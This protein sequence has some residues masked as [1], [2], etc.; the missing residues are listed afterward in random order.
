MPNGLLSR[1]PKQGR[2][3]GPGTRIKRAALFIFFVVFYTLG[4][5]YH[6][7]LWN[8]GQPTAFLT[9]IYHG[10]ILAGYGTLWLLLSSQFDRVRATPA[11]AFWHTLVLGILLIGLS[12]VTLNIPGAFNDAGE[13]L[14]LT[15]IVKMNTLSLLEATF[16]FILLLRFRDLVLFK[17][18]RSSQRNWYLMLAFMLFAVF[19][20]FFNLPGGPGGND[21]WRDYLLALAIIPAVTFMVINS[22]RISW[23]VHLTFREKMAIIGLSTLLLGLFTLIGVSLQTGDAFDNLMPGVSLYLN[24]YSYPLSMFMMLAGTFGFLYC[25]TALLSLMFHLPTTSDFQRR[26]DE[27]A[28]MHSLTDLVNQVFDPEKLVSTITASP[29]EAGSADAAW[30]A[31]ADLETGSLRPRV[32]ATHNIAPALVAEMVDTEA[33]YEEVLHTKEPVLLEQAHA[34]HRIAA[35]SGNG[36]SSLLVIPL[37]A[38]NET[39]GA[40]FVTRNVAH[41]FEKDDVE[42]I[43][44]FAAQAA[45][46]LDN[47]RLFEEQIEKE[48]LSREL[49]I[50]KEVQHKLLPQHLPMLDGLTLA[51]TSVSAQEVGGDYYDFVQLDEHRLAFI[52]GDVS[53]K[54]TSAAFYMA[55]M[56]GVFQSVTHI[57]PDPCD[58]LTHA[59]RALCNSLEKNVFIS[60]VY[61]VLDL[62]EEVLLMARAGHCPA[63]TINLHGESRY[64]RSQGLGLGL[65]RGSLFRKTLDVERIPLQPGDVFVL[66]TD[67][68][69]ESRNPQ[70]EE[71]GYDRLLE[72]LRAHRHED[73]PDLH[74][75]LMADLDRFLGGLRQYDDDLTLVVLKWHG[76]PLSPAAAATDNTREIYPARAVSLE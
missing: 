76:L 21:A 3:L 74:A 2:L 46:A 75:S 60:V 62:Q 55:E 10:V 34:D 7:L 6:L 23:I 44:I 19:A 59:N 31:I 50:A 40:L 49:A 53:G 30:L 65:D 5:A 54:G 56:Q 17:R 15:T 13:P 9:F 35:H 63:A 18:T 52:V 72:A 67:G 29:V 66:Y 4:A 28:V 26:A 14:T 37:S 71:Y 32:I 51:A 11:K 42:A 27:M 70:G 24:N 1:L 61:G 22:F 12:F 45:L 25:I 47:A 20:A 58:F 69:V 16:F 43:S 33:F 73:A 48:R 64:V 39:L 36:L 8:I 57:A 68:L 41:G 38:R